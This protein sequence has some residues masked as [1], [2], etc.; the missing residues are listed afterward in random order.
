M[1]RVSGLKYITILSSKR[2]EWRFLLLVFTFVLEQKPISQTTQANTEHAVPK[3]SLPRSA[4][5]SLYGSEGGAMKVCKLSY[6]GERR[7]SKTTILE[8]AAWCFVSAWT[9][10]K[11]WRKAH[12]T[13]AKAHWTLSPPEPENCSRTRPVTYAKLSTV[14][15]SKMDIP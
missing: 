11:P 5:G 14:S 9:Q 1:W 6:T 15:N 2:L 10:A 3:S 4:V 7:Q 8:S 12:F 13:T